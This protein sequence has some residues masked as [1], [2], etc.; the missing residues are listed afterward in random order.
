MKTLIIYPCLRPERPHRNFPIG[1]AYIASAIER[2]GY[3]FDILDIEAH[4]YTASGLEDILKKK[5]FDV[6]AFGTLVTG[7]KIAKFLSRLIRDINKDAVIIAGNSVASSIPEVLL[8]KTEVDIA[9]MGEGDITIVELLDAIERNRPLEEVKGIYFKRNGKIISTPKRQVIPEINRIPIPNWDIFDMQVYVNEAIHDIAEPYPIPKES[10]RA[11]V[12][13][14][15]RGCPFH[16]TF[17]YHVFRKDKYRY[18]TPESI[19]SEIVLLQKKYGINYINFYDEL[20]FFSKKQANE[21]VDK[22]LESGLKFFWNADVRANLFTED[23]IEILKKFKKAGCIGL[24]YSLESGYPDILK[25]MNKKLVVEDFIRQKK[26][27]DLVNIKTFTSIVLGYPQ[28]T[29]ETLK[30]TFDICY[31]LDVYPSV[32][33]LLPQPGTPMYELAKKNGLIE[34]EEEYLLGLGDRQDLRI[35]LTNMP[36]DV[37]QSEVKKH[38]K[39]IADKLSLNLSEERL[40]KTG[41]TV[42]SKK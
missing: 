36:D 5:E 9:V 24:G 20:T 15:A 8:S 13:N 4:R 30:Q 23:D 28:E 26:A 14:T 19:L 6:V 17:C 35:N 27:L 21:F 3:K 7:Y 16:C 39:R 25:S 41:K 40:I 33:Y 11:F 32:G 12:M 31:E 29:P 38:L 10:I 18:R 37:F 34:D 2:A 42:M 1:L 22:L